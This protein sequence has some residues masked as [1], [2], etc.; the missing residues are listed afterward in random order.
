MRS[1][2]NARSSDTKA[3]ESSGKLD[4]V[5][6]RLA[7]FSE[8]SVKLKNKVVGAL[9]YPLY[10]THNVGKAIFL[11][12]LTAGPLWVRTLIA[13]LFS[14]ALAWFVMWTAKRFVVPP[15][16]WVLNLVRLRDK[17]VA[18]PAVLEGAK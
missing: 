4:V 8:A 2:P 12:Q 13:I 18:K 7:D 10:L 3:G 6:L 15:L 17:P 14:L 11:Q 5:L 1:T 16:K 9:T